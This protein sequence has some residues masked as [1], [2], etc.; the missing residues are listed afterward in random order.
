MFLEVCV[1]TACLNSSSVP[2]GT[3]DLS[4]N[5]ISQTCKSSD[6]TFDTASTTVNEE[7]FAN[8]L[9]SPY[10][11]VGLATHNVS[12]STTS[13]STVINLES[14][15]NTKHT[16]LNKP[17]YPSNVVAN[18][19]SSAGLRSSD[20]ELNKTSANYS[21]S[22]EALQF[23]STMN[24]KSLLSASK[25]ASLPLNTHNLPKPCIESVVSSL[26]Q[27]DFEELGDEALFGVQSVSFE[28]SLDDNASTLYAGLDVVSPSYTADSL[29]ASPVC[30]NDYSN[31]STANDAC[32][33]NILEAANVYPDNE[34]SLVTKKNEQN[35]SRRKRISDQKEDIALKSK[36]RN[37]N[38]N[39]N[40]VQRV[41]KQ[42]NTELNNSTP[43][44]ELYTSHI[45]NILPSNSGC[46]DSKAEKKNSEF[47]KTFKPVFCANERANSEITASIAKSLGQSTMI[48]SDTIS[49]KRN[50]EDEESTTLQKKPRRVQTKLL[51]THNS[52]NVISN[53]TDFT[54]ASPLNQTCDSLNTDAGLN[55]TTINTSVS[56]PVSSCT[57][58]S[59]QSDSA[60]L[61]STVGNECLLN[62][63]VSD[64]LRL[65]TLKVATCSAINNESNN[66]CNSASNNVSDNASNLT[67][68]PSL[69]QT[70]S[71]LISHNLGVQSSN[72][73]SYCVLTNS[74]KVNACAAN[75]S[76]LNTCSQSNASQFNCWND[77]QRMLAYATAASKRL[78]AETIAQKDPRRNRKAVENSVMQKAVP[79]ESACV[80]LYHIGVNATNSFE[81]M[82][83]EVSTLNSYSL[84]TASS[85]NKNIDN[86]LLMNNK[87]E[88]CS[89]FTNT[90][91][92]HEPNTMSVV[93]ESNNLAN[94]C[95]EIMTDFI[96]ESQAVCDSSALDA[97]TVASQIA[98]STKPDSV[99]FLS[100]QHLSLGHHLSFDHHL[101]SSQ[102]LSLSTLASNSPH[103]LHLSEKTSTASVPSQLKSVVAEET[104][105][106][107]PNSSLLPQST[108]TNAKLTNKPAQLQP[109][110]T[111][112]FGVS[113]PVLENAS[114]A[115]CNKFKS[116][117]SK[118]SALPI[119][120]IVSLA[121]NISVP[122]SLSK[123]I[124]EESVVAFT[125]NV[126][127]NKPEVEKFASNE[128]LK[129]LPVKSKVLQSSST[130]MQPPSAL[131]ISPAQ[132]SSVS[133]VVS[134]VAL[135]PSTKIVV[136]SVVPP[137]SSTCMLSGLMSSITDAASPALVSSLL[138][139]VTSPVASFPSV[140]D[141]VSSASQFPLEANIMPT[142]PYTE[143]KQP[144]VD[145]V[146]SSTND[147][148]CAPKMHSSRLSLPSET[149]CSSQVTEAISGETVMIKHAENQNKIIV[150]AK[151]SAGSNAS[152]K[153]DLTH[154]RNSPDEGCKKKVDS[155]RRTSIPSVLQS[156]INLAGVE[157]SLLEKHGDVSK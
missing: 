66:V 42:G 157:Y 65:A 31:I 67:V 144:F 88:P 78:K 62:S 151:N 82:P 87:S 8:I 47:C 44:D 130:I 124:A 114:S 17:S 118:F 28:T 81:V 132:T 59:L 18:S 25:T 57:I 23:T 14:Y 142:M 128:S 40:V 84:E 10:L 1:K 11:S 145:S 20:L 27:N 136:S 19:S 35:D 86:S 105:M 55:V 64:I 9:L 38:I 33:A 92:S 75:N 112:T 53:Y 70:N 76:C 99:H 123:H 117:F 98:T 133:S 52:P 41:K 36:L 32:S 39:D 30:A 79:L 15:N 101:S 7:K 91:S 125:L 127:Q 29:N 83:A 129:L 121:S 146:P 108:I 24:K 73:A 153:I 107:T 94:I 22:T 115:T 34:T 12:P 5:D 93:Q 90:K 150:K 134:S 147:V 6:A 21:S 3:V 100:N 46:S 49:R 141:T 58:L 135:S 138:T 97:L 156:L 68:T 13:L 102:L 56:L 80:K 89:L 126:Q 54:T 60:S 116:Q 140:S 85:L 131:N 120:H 63:A 95:D 96:A 155:N 122:T 51:Y 74:L 45:Y 148:P 137:S 152:A 72:S 61:L 2:D 110:F 113:K 48:S 109:T 71:A 69:I 104:V 111:E 154:N 149:I 143:I 119:T 37:R 26:H 43:V 50:N 16:I 4:R 139:N 77:A 106:L 103:L